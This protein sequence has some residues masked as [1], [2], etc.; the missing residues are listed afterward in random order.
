MC[1][2]IH[3]YISSYLSSNSVSISA[4][5][6]ST[7][8]LQFNGTLSSVTQLI[9]TFYRI[10]LSLLLGNTFS[11]LQNSLRF[12]PLKSFRRMFHRFSPFLSAKVTLYAL[13]TSNTPSSNIIIHL[14]EKSLETISP[15]SF[16]LC[17]HG[18]S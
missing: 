14:K 4:P 10:V 15:M 5:T 7:Q 11:H 18:R 1:I 8:C 17:L 3:E 6:F 12:Y 13:L 16:H 2:Y 9:N